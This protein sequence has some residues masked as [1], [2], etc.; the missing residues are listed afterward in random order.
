[1]VK[2]KPHIV[3]KTCVRVAIALDE[4]MTEGKL[5]LPPELG[6]HIRQCPTCGPA[7]AEVQ[8][9]L[10]RLRSAPAGV[11]VGPVPAVVERV[12]GE[13]RRVGAVWVLLQFGAVALL[14]LVAALLVMALVALGGRMI[15][16]VAFYP[17]FEGS[18]HSSAISPVV[19]RDLVRWLYLFCNEHIR[20]TC[21]RVRLAGCQPAV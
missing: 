17:L 16:L 6:A 11:S 14:L 19:D 5:S 18:V 13:R 9:L 10:G 15:G 1:M 12:L 20:V 2:L 8:E 21:A 7:A 3:T 4:A